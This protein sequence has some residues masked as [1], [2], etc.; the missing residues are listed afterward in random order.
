MFYSPPKE[1]LWVILMWWLDNAP[2]FGSEQIVVRH[3]YPNLKDDPKV[4]LMEWSN[5]LLTASNFF[6]LHLIQSRMR[7]IQTPNHFPTISLRILA[8]PL[9]LQLMLPL[10]FLHQVSVLPAP[11]QGLLV[12]SANLNCSYPPSSSSTF[13]F[14]SL[15]LSLYPLFSLWCPLSS[16]LPSHFP[17]SL[18]HPFSVSRGFAKALSFILLKEILL[19]IKGQVVWSIFFSHHTFF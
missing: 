10:L 12:S 16:L 3:C 7:R 9:L 17:W 6:I 11:L 8:P 15:I 4:S 5:V 14:V 19:W 13:G 2:S 18:C 1:N